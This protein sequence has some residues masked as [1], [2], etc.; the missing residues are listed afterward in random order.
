MIETD[1]LLV[2][3]PQCGAWPMAANFPKGASTQEIRFK[4][5][6]CQHVRGGDLRRRLIVRASEPTRT[7][8]AQRPARA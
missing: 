4:C 7:T 8:S 1:S 6:R 5:T 2:K 3:C